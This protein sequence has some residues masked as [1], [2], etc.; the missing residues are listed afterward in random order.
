[1]SSIANIAIHDKACTI[2]DQWLESIRARS[3]SYAKRLSQIKNAYQKEH[4]MESSIQ[5]TKKEI[6]LLNDACRG[7]T[8][9]EIALEHELSIN[10]VKSMFANIFV[11]LGAVNIVDAVRLA[12]QNNLL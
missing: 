7:L 5:L 3:S 6:E 10:T 11:K 4:K 2:P 8:R 9:E 1:M 12:A